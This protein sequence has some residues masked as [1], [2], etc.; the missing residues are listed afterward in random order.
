MLP[1]GGRE[2]FKLPAGFNPP[3]CAGV[4]RRAS[5]AR[6]FL[7]S[8]CRSHR[9]FPKAGFR[10]QACQPSGNSA[11][12]LQGGRDPALL[13]SRSRTQCFCLAPPLSKGRTDRT[14]RSERNCWPQRASI[15]DKRDARGNCK[16]SKHE[17]VQASTARKIE[18]P[19]LLA[20]TLVICVLRWE[21]CQCTG[22]WSVPD[23]RC[24]NS[25]HAC[26]CTVGKLHFALLRWVCLRQPI[27]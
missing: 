4:L 16:T 19:C 1:S 23:L 14:A 15:A 9:V 11:K 27:F 10:A 13:F 12:G 24:D 21:L 8:C 26:Y 17:P 7:A 2:H 25:F 22:S 3:K 20:W 6:P 18:L 5:R